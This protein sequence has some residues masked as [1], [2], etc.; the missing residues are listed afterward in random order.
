MIRNF[1][2]EKEVEFIVEIKDSNGGRPSHDYYVTKDIATTLAIT[3]KS[4]F[5]KEIRQK[6]IDNLNQRQNLQ[7]ITPEEAIFATAVIDC[8]ESIINKRAEG[9]FEEENIIKRFYSRNYYLEKHDSQTFI[10]IVKNTMAELIDNQGS[11]SNSISKFS[12][13]IK[14][15]ANRMDKTFIHQKQIK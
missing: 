8:M 3:S 9:D 6:I 2:I 15:L 12:L 13:M 7:L 1:G 14:E 4:K 5:G 10:D 11:E